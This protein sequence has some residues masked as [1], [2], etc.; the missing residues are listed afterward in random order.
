M[1]NKGIILKI[2]TE[3][4][5]KA[6]KSA[7]ADLRKLDSESR[8]TTGGLQ[9]FGSKLSA[10]VGPALLGTAA[11]AGT[12]ALAFAVEGVKSAAA[13][14]QQLALL[15]NALDNVNQGFKLP[16]IS[17]AIDKLQMATGVLDTDLRPAFQT[18]VTATRDAAEAQDLLSLAVDISVAKQKDL[19]SVA[20]A[21]AKA[22]NGQATAL[23][24]LGVP[25]SDGAKKAGN[26]SIAVGELGRAFGGAAAASVDTFA[27]KVKLIQIAIDEAKESFGK[28]FLTGIETGLGGLTDLKDGLVNLQPDFE[29]LGRSVG[30]LAG[31]LLSLITQVQDLYN[32]L[33]IFKELFNPIKNTANQFQI[34][35]LAIET[36]V[37][38][39]GFNLPQAAQLTEE[40]LSALNNTDWSVIT[41]NVATLTEDLNNAAQDRDVNLFLKFHGASAP[42]VGITS[43][44]N[45]FFTELYKAQDEVNDTAGTVTEAAK[46]IDPFKAWSDSLRDSAKKAAAKTKLLAMGLPAEL[47]DSVINADGWKKVY[48]RLLKGGSGTIKDFIS[49]WSK[50]AEGQAAI[51]AQVDKITGQIKNRLDKAKDAI[52]DFKNLSRDF[53]QSIKDFGAISTFQPDTGVPITAAG[54]TANVRQRLAMVREFSSVLQ[55]LQSA[56]VPLNQAAL[57]DLVGMGPM[58]GLPY[59]K[60]LLEAG[61]STISG[62]NKLQGQF[63]TPANIIANIGAEAQTGTNMAALQGATN[64][65]VAQGGINIT[66]NG[67]IT[68]QTRQ[69]IETAVTN[70]FIRVGRERRNARRA[71]V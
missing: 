25:L 43:A 66:V 24:R 60:A 69:D 38:Q 16:E 46:K 56:K 19:G 41:G 37:G 1:A 4:T 39:L 17:N 11:A 31:Q 34:F 45:D 13:E 71:G 44:L 21:L 42:G 15:K 58:E 28:G 20:T 68:A 5:N 6:M 57:L 67:E 64:F 29:E 59:A 40:Q 14:E 3:Y 47:A 26:F 49:T 12:M 61:A 70:A 54:I 32:S 35:G 33:G 7:Q 62:L 30:E 52:D 63:V 65:T 10:F 53:A 18:L 27:G 2:G 22:S 23:T 8:K 9:S 51:A 48:A 50:G 55:Q 36:V